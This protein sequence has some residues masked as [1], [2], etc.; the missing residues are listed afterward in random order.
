MESETIQ[1][2]QKG[3]ASEYFP[4]YL[5]ELKKCGRWWKAVEYWWS[6][7]Q[8]IDPFNG[9]EFKMEAV[10]DIHSTL[11]KIKKDFCA[12]KGTEDPK[13]F[14]CVIEGHLTAPTTVFQLIVE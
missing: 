11:G 6:M 1:K 2:R 8:I 9:S 13:L 12:E 7:G 10:F 14:S 5:F 3:G 4:C